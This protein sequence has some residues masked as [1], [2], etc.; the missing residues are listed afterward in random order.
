MSIT[1]A[2]DDI[3][4]ARTLLV[5]VQTHEEAYE[6]GLEAIERLTANEPVDE[7]DTVSFPSV[8]TLFETFTPQTM[9]LLETIAEREPES[10][11]ETARL[12]ERDVKNVH[13]DL[14][15]LATLGVIRFEESG[16][17]K[18]PIF[19]YD[20]LVISLPFGSDRVQDAA[21]A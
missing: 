1:D 2:F 18:R 17:A 4:T 9:E 19:P 10:I 21:P 12:V 15:E 3:P 7:P 20:E 11:R 8:P 13:Q 6:Q 14:T 16:R 5:T